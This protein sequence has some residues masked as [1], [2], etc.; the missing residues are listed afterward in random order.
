MGRDESSYPRAW[1][2]AR[3]SSPTRWRRTRSASAGLARR[4]Y[5]GTFRDAAAR[6]LA[7][8]G[9]RPS[10][11]VLASLSGLLD[12]R[13]YYN[14]HSWYEMFSYLPG[15]D[16]YRESWDRLM[17]VAGRGASPPSRGARWTRAGALLTSIAILF[18]VKSL[19]RRFFPRFDAPRARFLEPRKETPAT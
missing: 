10:R 7:L 3:A 1:A 8:G 15:S 12:G 11:D 5:E 2:S 6:F 17:G 9:A 18:R 4:S 16:R 13:V 14:L 19:R